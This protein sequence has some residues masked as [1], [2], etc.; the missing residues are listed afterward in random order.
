MRPPIKLGS[1]KTVETPFRPLDRQVKKVV[2]D[3]KRETVVDSL[4]RVRSSPADAIDDIVAVV[5]RTRLTNRQATMWILSQY[6][7]GSDAIAR[8]LSVPE[9]IIRSDLATVDRITRQSVEERHELSTSLNH[10]LDS[11]QIHSPATWMGLNWSRWF[12]LQDWETLEKNC[13]A[14]RPLPS[15]T[16]RTPGFDVHRGV[17]SGRRSSTARRL[18]L[19]AGVNESERQT[20]NKQ[21]RCRPSPSANY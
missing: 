16:L 19:S 18:G 7:P 10:L 9:S 2:S 20:G 8:I 21:T 17:G 1:P 3:E 5:D 11:N 12:E 15:Q 6:V 14:A 4:S 13:P